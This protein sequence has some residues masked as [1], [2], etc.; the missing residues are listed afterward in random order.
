M[1]KKTI[2]WFIPSQIVIFLITIFKNH[3][4]N[5]L[6]YINI[7][8]MLGGL[9]IFFGLT[10]YVL[11]SGFFDVTVY[12]FRR[13]FKVNGKELS[14]EELNEMRPF[15]ELVSFN[16]LP[17]LLNGILILAIMFICLFIYY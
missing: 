4:V 9:F 14:R 10:I 7:S 15:S 1:L 11:S 6:H 2:Y 17:L 8:F 3:T 5:L 13:V 12:S 16:F